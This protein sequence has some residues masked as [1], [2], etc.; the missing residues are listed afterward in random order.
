MNIKNIAIIAAIGVGTL[1]LVGCTRTM[2]KY[3][4][5]TTTVATSSS[6]A[7]SKKGPPPHAP[8]HGYRH[9]HGNTV[10]VYEK[11]LSLYIVSGHDGYYFH[12][13]KYY[14]Q[15]KGTWQ[16]AKSMDG[17]WKKVKSKKLPPGLRSHDQAKSNGKSKK[18]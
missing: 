2:V 3:S 7:S 18:K 14:R 15:H 6:T 17:K 13:D 16:A 1:A 11:S 8:A 5:G 12:D 10:L 9:K 4:D